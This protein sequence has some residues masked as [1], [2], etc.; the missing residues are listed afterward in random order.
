MQDCMTDERVCI[1]VVSHN[2][3]ELTNSLC[4]K[5]IKNTK[6]VKYDLHVIETGSDI[7]LI[8]K[9]TTL[10]VS[11]GCRMTRGFNLLKNYADTVLKYKS[12]KKYSAYMLF[13]N[14][15]KFINNEDMVSI[16]FSEMKKIP[17]CG[18]IHPYQ[19]NIGYPHTRLAK[20]SAN[21]TRK[22]SFVEIVCPMISAKAWDECGEN[23]LDNRFFYGWGLD[24]D[25]PYQLHKKGFR[26]YITDKVGVHHTAFTSY[27]DKKI[28]KEKLNK[29]EFVLT[30]RKNMHDGMINKY[31]EN[32][33]EKMVKSVPE[34]V[35]DEALFLW[36]HFNDGYNRR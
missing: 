15:A 24:Y 29:Q 30:A 1:L 18:Q 13:V 5:I 23:L 16:L 11:D 32:W 3:P 19:Q 35:P 4:E 2:N 31:G 7:K 17:D 28:T 27:R 20:V 25:I 12:N 21:L 26:T 22:E 36:L 9:Y 8:S 6:S 33:M 14:D 34:D 10:W